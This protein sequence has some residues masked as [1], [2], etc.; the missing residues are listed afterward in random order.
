MLPRYPSAFAAVPASIAAQPIAKAIAWTGIKGC[1]LI[2]GSASREHG[3][4]G[5]AADVKADAAEVFVAVEGVVG[6]RH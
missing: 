1:D 2:G 5:D 4:V 3:D 6:E